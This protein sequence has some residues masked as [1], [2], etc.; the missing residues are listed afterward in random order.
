M[1]KEKIK[2]W[3]K[4]KH[5]LTFLGIIILAIIIRIYYFSLTKTQ[6]LWW[7]EADYMA[8]AK[9]LAGIN[10]GWTI[11][12]QHS[13]LFSFLV[14]GLF[15]L[16]FT[17]IGIKFILEFLPSILLVFVTYK[18]A[19]LMY[20]KK[21]ALISAFLMTVFW[22]ILFNSFRFHL[23]VPALLFAFLA[24]YSF[25]QGYEK[26]QKIFGKIN[27]NWA[28][29]ITVSFLVIAY[30]MRRSFFLFVPGFIIYILLTRN[31][32][33]LIKDKNNWIALGILLVLLII[34][35]NFIF[36][37]PVTNVTSSYFNKDQPINLIPLQV[38]P[39]YFDSLTSSATSV[40]TYLCYIGIFLMI[41]TILFSF[42]D[43]K[44]QGPSRVK[45]DLFNLLPIL[46]TLLWF[47]LI[48]RR[49]F[50]IGDPRWYFPL[51]LG[52]FIAISKSTVLI[53]DLFKKYNKHLAIILIIVLIGY[54]GYY[55]LQHADNIIKL[56]IPTYNGIK[57]AGL[58]IKD[59]S[60]P[61][62]I[63][64]SVPNS[65][66]SY[67]AERK[68]VTPM[69]FTNSEGNVQT[70]FNSFISEIKKPEN[71]NVKYF[72]VTF[73]EPGHPLWMRADFED[74]IEIPFM[75]TTISKIS[76]A[77]QILNTKTYDNIEFRLLTIQ[78]DAFVYEIARL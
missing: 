60:Q 65:Q 29:P 8:Y 53:S 34:V 46:A 27:P 19:L 66:P 25:F 5:N 69:E 32:K 1:E 41:I 72:I 61:T 75:D 17:E 38:F 74:R 57:Q 54:G 20:N 58:F 77:H 22:N 30:A 52:S 15:R 2:S 35:E 47:I 49:E 9:N 36:V 11:T 39:T 78:E 23:G 31:I 68:V 62:D 10:N 73:S 51:L 14:A 59:V 56:K 40:L 16:G 18:L 45:S 48:Q 43:L 3:L 13:S 21:I 24:I 50:F 67:Y 33:D 55:Q 26:K 70:T 64:F 71:N 37:S 12:P 7:D 42:K 28:I 76:N 4:D 44:K 63:I 6:P